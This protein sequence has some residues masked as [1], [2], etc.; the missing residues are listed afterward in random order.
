MAGKNILIVA[1][2]PD[3]ET[4]GVGGTLFKHRAAGDEVHWLIMTS[5]SEQDG[6]S[7]EFRE[8]RRN[9]IETVSGMYGF[10]STI[11]LDFRA[12]Q[13]DTYP[14]AELVHAIST[15]MEKMN[16]DTIYVPNRSDVHSDH[17]A[18]HGAVIA[19]TKSFRHPYL[20]RVMMYETL[21]ETEFAMPLMENAFMPNVYSDITN[22]MDEKLSAMAVYVSECGDHPFPRS[23]E[24]LRALA[25]LRGSVAHV[26]YA[27]AFMLLKEF[28]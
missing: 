20:K 17:Q 15:V 13:L 11:E 23:P 9:E 18:A 4:L 12:T 5:A 25:T 6:Y 14:T 21:S 7:A 24:T 26:K 16:P 8:K 10:A 19:C 3:D 28:C 2:H 22:Y 1:T 27:E